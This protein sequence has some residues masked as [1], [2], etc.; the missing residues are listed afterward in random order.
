MAGGQLVGDIGLAKN[1]LASRA[2]ELEQVVAEIVSITPDRATRSDIVI[3]AS[4]AG[5]HVRIGQMLFNLFG[6]AIAFSL[7]W[8]RP[9]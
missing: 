8:S 5:D 7:R 2:P 3:E 9:W 1:A 4:T 6:N